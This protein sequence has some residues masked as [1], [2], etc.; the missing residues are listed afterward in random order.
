M[1]EFAQLKRIIT[2]ILITSLTEVDDGNSGVAR[3]NGEHFNNGF[4]KVEY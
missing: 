4:D 2:V 1:K 3:P